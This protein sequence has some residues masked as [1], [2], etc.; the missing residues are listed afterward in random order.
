MAD[1]AIWLW[2]LALSSEASGAYNVGAAEA[3]SIR[4]TANRVAL[5]VDPRVH[6]EVEGKPSPGQAPQRYVPSVDRMRE[7]LAREPLIGLEEGI[8]RTAVWHNAGVDFTAPRGS[9]Q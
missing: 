9:N 7:Q 6:V 1:L 5:V 2:T 3:V 8:R 4:E